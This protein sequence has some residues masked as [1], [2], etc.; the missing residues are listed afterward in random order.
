MLI[1]G[2]PLR[3][4][5]LQRKFFATSWWKKKILV[6]KQERMYG[7]EMQ[8]PIPRSAMLIS[9][10]YQRTKIE[11]DKT[12]FHKETLAVDLSSA[13]RSPLHTAIAWAIC[14]V[15]HKTDYM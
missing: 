3:T 10:I 11:R 4:K 6:S 1:L 15:A 12:S 13:A 9:E 5:S 7:V 8:Y 2:R 14:H